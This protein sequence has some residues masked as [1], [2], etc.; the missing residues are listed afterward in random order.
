MA[1]TVVAAA[2]PADSP[3]E[4]WLA[5]IAIILGA[6]V[7]ILNNSLINVAIPQL[8]TD[9]GSTTSRIQWVITGY[10]L[11]SGIIVPITGFMEQ[12]IGYKKFLIAALSV[13]T[14]GTAFCIFAWS[15][16]S[17]IAARILAGLGGGVIMPLS[18]TI[19]YKIMPREQIGMALGIWGVAAMAAPA[20][21]PTLSGYLIE[22]FNWRFLF[23]VCIPVALFAILMVIVLI[24]EPPKGAIVKFDLAGFLLAATCAGTLLYALSSGS[25]D[26]WSSFKIV[27]LFFV[28]FWSLVFLIFVESGKDNPVIDISLFKNYKFTISVITSS[29][30]MMGLYGGTFLSPLFLQNIQS[31]SPV[32]TGII[33]LPQAIAMAVMMPIA[34]KLFDKIGIVPIALFGLTL[35]SIMTYHLHTLT[36]DTSHLWLQVVL[37]FR[38][39]GIGIC[40]MPL[41]TVGMNA[42]APEKVGKA[43]TASN[44]VRTIAGS[45][46]IAILT[47]LMQSRTALHSQQISES[48]TLDGAQTL[49]ATLGSS[50]A[51][52]TSGLITLDAYSRGIA[53]TFLVSSIPLF[54]SIPFIFLFISRRKGVKVIKE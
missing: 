2:P 6:F 26:G 18:M 51:S 37:M 25:S 54:C 34:G 1:D 31:V 47:F 45:M 10:T 13:F 20:I 28:A 27:G 50:W 12:R 19:V 4:R 49:Q 3:R 14:L 46:A 23:I 41:S 29:F 36:P 43:S 8:T 53:D 48:I 21:G 35:T 44:L 15:D 40:M 11:A 17:L 24:K 9:L 30:V 42:V 16:S 38:G 22:W 7:A 32:H 39:M 5:F 33:L 52:I